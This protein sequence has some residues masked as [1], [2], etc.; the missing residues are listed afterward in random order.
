MAEV[1]SLRDKLSASE[2]LMMEMNRSWSE[3]LRTAERMRA[4][5]AALLEAQGLSEDVRK[6][7][8]RMPNLVN[9]NEDPQ[10]AEMLIYIIK[11]G[12]TTVGKDDGCDVNL[13][14]MFVRG[15]H[16][17]IACSAEHVVELTAVEDAILYVNGEGLHANETRRLAHGDRII[18]GNHHFFR[19]N[20]PRDVKTRGPAAPEEV[21]VRDYRFAREEFDRVQTARIQAELEGEHQREKEAILVQ[22]ETAKEEARR[23]LTEQQSV[24]EQRLRAL[25]A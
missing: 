21:N 19:L 13:Q 2:R 20:I 8:N 11:E 16:A 10:L 3:K 12:R 24:F 7:G 14:G 5:N 15:Q 23:N 17:V 9:L 6:V 1:S 25:V 4:E 18:I 22:L